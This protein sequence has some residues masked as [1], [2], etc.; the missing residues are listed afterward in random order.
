MEREPTKQEYRGLGRWLLPEHSI[1]GC[2]LVLPYGSYVAL[3]GLGLF[4]VW[5]LLKRTS[6]IASL[7]YRQGWLW[8]TLGLIFNVLM[9]YAPG[10]SALQSLNF[11]PFFWFYAALAVAIPK[12]YN[13]GQ[14]LYRWALGLV[15]VSLPISLRAMVEFYF[16]APAN[17]ERWAGASWLDWLYLQ[18]DFGHRADAVFGHPNVLANYLVIVFGLGLGLCMLY[19]NQ[20]RKAPEAVWVYGAVALV[21]V[22]IF[23]SG[24][25]NGLLIAGIQLILFAWCMRRFRLI[26]WSGLGALLAVL[27]GVLMWGVG[28]R[29]LGEALQTVTLRF[30]VWRLAFDLINDHP[31]IGSGL[32]TFKLRYEPYSIPIYDYVAHPHNLILMFAAELG[33]P[34]T[35]LFTGIVGI[36]AFRGVRHLFHLPASDPN[37]FVLAAYFLGFAGHLAFAMFDLSFYDSRINV[38]GWL[39]LAIIQSSTTL[40][41]AL[42]GSGP[43]LASPSGGRNTGSALSRP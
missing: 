6:A 21:L 12:F 28:G 15:L 4:L 26:I 13:P 41:P 5:S 22:G 24:S 9:S 19:L 23:C 20:T 43:K 37:R 18:P 31:W 27:V 30:D 10:E 1:L 11:I 40:V 42:S 36:I 29:S 25:R 17:I 33:L 39:M 2:L 3:V 14:T 7:L 38:L 16:K 34:M 35:L 8:L 32:G